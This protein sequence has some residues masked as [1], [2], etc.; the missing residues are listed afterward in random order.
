MI[1]CVIGEEVGVP[2][3]FVFGRTIEF[4]LQFRVYVNLNIHNIRVQVTNSVGAASFKTGH[5]L[6]DAVCAL[7]DAVAAREQHAHV[8]DGAG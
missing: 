5:A 1:F 8:R 7:G 3:A 6:G 2:Q 4:A